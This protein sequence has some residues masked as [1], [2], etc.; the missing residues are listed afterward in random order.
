VWYA[1]RTH[2]KFFEENQQDE[3]GESLP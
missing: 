2:P 3:P 1:W